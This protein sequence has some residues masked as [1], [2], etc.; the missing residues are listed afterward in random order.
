MTRE[1]LRSLSEAQVR[2]VIACGGMLV[3][4]GGEWRAHRSR[5]ARRKAAGRITLLI[6]NRL[7]SEGAVL[8]DPEK[9]G[10]LIAGRASLRPPPGPV[11]LPA[12]VLQAGPFRKPVSLFAGIV[13]DAACDQGEM[14]RLKAAAQRFLA[15]I[16]LAAASPKMSSRQP[17]R[18]A[19]ADPSAA[20][21]RLAALETAIGLSIFRQLECLLVSNASPA[22]F[23]RESGRAMP[24]APA[25]AMAAL[26]ALAR[27]YDL[28][29]KPPRG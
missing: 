21:C 22:A 14:T 12:Q 9:P 2:Q 7:R 10:R 23:A 4:V 27:A 24:E 29:I 26:R 25:A 5:D 15:D 13:R 3:E 19:R 17:G 1:H 8:P 11:P 18:T 20:L 6:A 16:T 28:G